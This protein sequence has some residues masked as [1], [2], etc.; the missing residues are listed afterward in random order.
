MD[1]DGGSFLHRRGE[2]NGRLFHSAL[3]IHETA[4]ISRAV[5]SFSHSQDSALLTQIRRSTEQSG[6]RLFGHSRQHIAL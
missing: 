3:L 2:A 6:A 1:S 4:A 5:L